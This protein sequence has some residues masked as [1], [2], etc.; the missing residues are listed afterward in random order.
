MVNLSKVGLVAP[1]WRTYSK[2]GPGRRFMDIFRHKRQLLLLVSLNARGPRFSP[3]KV[4]CPNPTD[5]GAPQAH[6]MCCAFD[7]L[8]L[9]GMLC[10][11]NAPLV[12]FKEVKRVNPLEVAALHR[13]FWNAGRLLRIARSEVHGKERVEHRHGSISRRLNDK[14]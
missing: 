13:K 7:L 6:I 8:K 3:R 10:A 4:R 2:P 11:E 9:D 12:Y 14:L 1:R 5:A